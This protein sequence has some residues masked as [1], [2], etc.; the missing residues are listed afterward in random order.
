MSINHGRI[1]IFMTYEFLGRS[2]IRSV[3]LYDAKHI[4]YRQPGIINGEEVDYQ[5]D[6]VT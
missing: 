1:Y 3:R 4:Q 5:I 2:N 6:I